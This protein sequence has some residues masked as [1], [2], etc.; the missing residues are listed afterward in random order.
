MGIKAWLVLAIGGAIVVSVALG[1]Q[2]SLR[3]HRGYDDDATSTLGDNVSAQ[4]P[5]RVSVTVPRDTH[6]APQSPVAPLVRFE[7]MTIQSGITFEHRDGSS[8]RHFTPET[9]SA[10]VATFDFDGDGLIDIYFPNGAALPGVIYDPPPRHALYRNLGDWQ[11]QEVSHLAGIDCTAF[12]LGIAIADYDNDGFPDIYLNNFGPNIL[13]RNNGDGTFTEV[14]DDAGVPGTTVSG[15]LSKK[16]GAGAVFL[17]LTGNGFLDLFSGNYIEIDLDTYVTPMKGHLPFYPTPM[18]Y[19]P[20]PN[21]LYENQG[22]GTFQD[23]S[24]VS[25]VAGFPGRCMGVISCDFDR[26]GHPDIFVCN[27]VFANFLLRND[28]QGRFTEVGLVAGVAMSPSAEMVA[29]MAVDAGDYDNDGWLDFFTTNYEQQYPLLLRNLGDGHFSN[30]TLAAHAGR[31][32]FHLVNWGCGLVDFDNDTHLDIFIGNGHTDSN[33]DYLESGGQYRCHNVVLW[34]TGEARFVDISEAAGLR[35]LPLRAARGIAFEDFDNDGDV[36]IVVLNSREPPTLLRNEWNEVGSQNHWL[37]IQLVGVQA[38]RD[39]VGARVDVTVGD[40]ALVREVHSGRGYQSHWG[41]R[42]HFGLGPH[43]RVDRIE[44]RWPG[45]GTQI[46]EQV[47]ADQLLKII[48][49]CL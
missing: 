17:D 12:G 40:L 48:Q 19:D 43:D 18:A 33:V 8:G 45:G 4:H 30:E 29:N 21:T 28:G 1:L 7:D 10:G 25:G 35:D 13:Y 6:D 26:D 32:V 11:F 42:L 38:N 46:L 15:D 3:S 14:T 24:M 39:G 22:D 16:V 31:S 47:P 37:Q 34:N 23:I 41:S 20:V 44:I 2:V 36:D 27:D 5:F 49:D 9:M